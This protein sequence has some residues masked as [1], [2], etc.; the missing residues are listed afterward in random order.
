MSDIIKVEVK[1]VVTVDWAALAT[2]IADMIAYD[3]KH[4][5][6]E[7]CQETIALNDLGLFAM[8]AGDASD[9]FAICKVL[10][11]GDWDTANDMI[12]KMD[13]QARDVMWRYLDAVGGKKFSNHYLKQRLTSTGVFA[14]ISV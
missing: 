14:N 3:L 8:Y 13:T 1:E 2:K 6:F 5:M 9:G 11:T 12:W 10:A 7:A 4:I